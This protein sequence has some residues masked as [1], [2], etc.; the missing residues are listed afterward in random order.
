MD[1][2]KLLADSRSLSSHAPASWLAT[3]QS[4]ISVVFHCHLN[5][6]SG[7]GGQRLFGVF[8]PSYYSFCLFSLGLQGYSR[9]LMSI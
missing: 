1:V 8:P 7:Y 4:V 5:G 9:D 6:F 2:A 3:A